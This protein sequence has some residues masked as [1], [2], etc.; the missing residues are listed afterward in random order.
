MG[1][2]LFSKSTRIMGRIAEGSS[3]AQA[4]EAGAA[5][6]L[7]AN[8]LQTGADIATKPLSWAL[9]M[10]SVGATGAAI[11]S[12]LYGQ[13]VSDGAFEGG[14]VGGISGLITGAALG[15][16]A[17]RKGKVV[18]SESVRALTRGAG[19]GDLRK[20][21]SLGDVLS[22]AKMTRLHVADMGKGE[23]FAANRFGINEEGKTFRR[24]FSPKDEMSVYRLQAHNRGVMNEAARSGWRRATSD[25]K[26]R[27]NNTTTGAFN[28][29][30][31]SINVMN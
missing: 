6:A 1:L 5:G 27:F 20:L 15:Y 4:M 12:P 2:N 3:M 10:G 11:A 7:K 31:H 18:G 28:D 16:A 25:V 23:N 9:G 29:K 14:K 8:G 13:T 19:I 21:H 22:D 30:I 17:I 24:A 26:T